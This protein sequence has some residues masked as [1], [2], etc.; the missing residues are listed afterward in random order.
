MF[1]CPV[2]MSRP[3]KKKE[4]NAV[5]PIQL[6]NLIRGEAAVPELA[7]ED[8][9]VPVDANLN[10]IVSACQSKHVKELSSYVRSVCMRMGLCGH[11]PD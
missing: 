6:A 10:D 8:L 7:E 11:M 3:R 1:F 5:I 9:H 4:K 2:D